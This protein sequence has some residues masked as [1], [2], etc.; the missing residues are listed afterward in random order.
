[1]DDEQTFSSKLSDGCFRVNNVGFFPSLN[2]GFLKSLFG[3]VI[4]IINK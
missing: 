1:M 2:F 3:L 4:I